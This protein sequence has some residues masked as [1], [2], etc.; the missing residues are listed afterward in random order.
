M[1]GEYSILPAV[2]VND[3]ADMGIRYCIFG[4]LLNRCFILPLTKH[5]YNKPVY[6]PT[7]RLGI[8]PFS[9]CPIQ[10][11]TSSVLFLLFVMSH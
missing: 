4:Q 5:M 3:D 10:G 9:K 11:G 2:T 7:F 1:V 6:A 8:L